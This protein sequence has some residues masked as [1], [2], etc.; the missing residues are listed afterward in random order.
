MSPNIGSKKKPRP[1]TIIDINSPNSLMGHD[2]LALLIAASTFLDANM[3]SLVDFHLSHFS[4]LYSL[5][6]SLPR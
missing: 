3:C 4:K 1:P 2:D 5:A 6:P